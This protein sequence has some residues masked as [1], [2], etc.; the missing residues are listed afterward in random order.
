[1]RGIAGL[2]LEGVQDNPSIAAGV[3]AFAVAF[4]LVAGN[5]LYG[6]QG[7]HPVPLFATRDA[8]T[9]KSLPAEPQ[10]R[11]QGPSAKSGPQA[12]I[13]QIPVPTAR[14]KPASPD[15]GALVR[16]MQA[17]LHELGI[18]SGDIDGLYGPRTRE[19]VVRFETDLG[20][21][22]TGQVTAALVA[23]LERRASQ[24]VP[25]KPVAKT[26]PIAEPLVT[27]TVTTRALTDEIEAQLAVARS[28]P[29]ASQLDEVRNEAIIARIKIG[30]INFGEAGITYDGVLDAATAS[31]IRK[32]QDRNG[33]EVDGLAS[34]ALLRKMEQ[35]GALKKS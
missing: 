8:M 11:S 19:A 15:T 2:M 23:A 25:A 12:K 26:G 5:A 14:P 17:G 1:M 7:G 31:A 21:E 10:K 33:L 20:V 27:N 28:E 32:F 18:Y 16:Q 4:S 24:A 29:V 22:P 35:I 9:T 30:L 6:Q 34:E 13:A 3:C